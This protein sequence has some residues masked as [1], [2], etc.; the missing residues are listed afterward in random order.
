M[1]RLEVQNAGVALRR[2]RR[3]RGSAAV[4]CNKLDELIGEAD[5]RLSRLVHVPS[6]PLDL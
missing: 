5:A 3:P 2:D 6:P 1:P 4:W